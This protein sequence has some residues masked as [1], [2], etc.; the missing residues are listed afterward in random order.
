MNDPRESRKQALKNAGN[1]KAIRENHHALTMRFLNTV[2]SSHKDRLQNI[3]QAVPDDMKER[4]GRLCEFLAIARTHINR[5]M[6]GNMACL[7]EPELP[8]RLTKSLV[9]LVDAY[10]IVHDRLPDYRDEAIALRLIHDNLPTERIAILKVM[11]CFDEPKKTSEIATAAKTPTPMTNRVLN[12]LATLGIITRYD[13]ESM[14][15][16]ADSWKFADGEFKEAF[17]IVTNPEIWSIYT[18]MLKVENREG[19]H[20]IS[21]VEAIKYVHDFFIKE[22]KDINKQYVEKVINTIHIH[23]SEIQPSSL[24]VESEQAGTPQSTELS[25]SLEKARTH[26]EQSEGAINSSNIDRFPFWFCEKYKPKWQGNGDSCDYLPS[27]VKPIA[28]KLFKLTP[29]VSA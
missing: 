29:G 10:S 8:T 11:A 24:K 19:S 20:V 28:A 22:K 2:F 21:N 13:K 16:N 1:E 5:D 6:K 9:K 25:I 14:D 26:W 12:D 3:T 23:L 7:P 15:T 4:I 18:E 27:M 17:L